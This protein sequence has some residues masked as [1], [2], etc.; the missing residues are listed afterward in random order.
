MIFLLWSFS[1][2]LRPA[3]GHGYCSS[4]RS[5]N[6]LKHLAGNES[7]PHCHNGG[8]PDVVQNAQ[9]QSSGD[10]VWPWPPQDEDDS[11][12]KEKD[13]RGVCGGLSGSGLYEQ[14]G[15]IVEENFYNEGQL[16]DVDIII[17]AH[18]KGHVEVRLCEVLAWDEDDC[19]GITPDNTLTQECL[20]EHVLL[21][22]DSGVAGV[23]TYEKLEFPSTGS[24]PNNGDQLETD[25]F[26]F[27]DCFPERY[28]LG[29][30]RDTPKD[31]EMKG[32]QWRL[33]YKVKLPDGV[34]C[35]HCVV[36]W[37]YLTGNSCD[38]PGYRE[39][40]RDITDLNG[41]QPC[42]ETEENYPEE[43]WNCASVA[44]APQGVTYDA[45]EHYT[46]P[47]S[48]VEY[49]AGNVAPSPG[50][51]PTGCADI[52]DRTTCRGTEGCKWKQNS[53]Q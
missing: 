30:R 33:Q 51:E 17:T 19:T 27:D 48:E 9:F 40:I 7:C 52:N 32:N 35:S 15:E 2:L 31:T 8:S 50:P 16:L 18:H 34:T 28:H 10:A 46:S 23:D 29:N 6:Y 38:P 12:P 26:G 44:I 42:G 22:T 36:Q 37:Y 53:C 20:N 24:C 3:A 14:F 47:C 49:S 41:N 11:L 4:P 25:P 45:A 21:R 43:F 5:H 1:S 39:S 13:R